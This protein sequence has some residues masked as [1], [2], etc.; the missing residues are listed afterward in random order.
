MVAD[1]VGVVVNV[2]AGRWNAG[3]LASALKEVGVSPL[4]VA[5]APE[6]PHR[7]TV[8]LHGPAGRSQQ[9]TAIAH[10]LRLEGIGRVDVS[11][12]TWTILRVELASE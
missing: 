8:Y 10:L 1:L 6:D 2:V 12:Y 4:H 3:T 7:F 5:V 11:A 9:E